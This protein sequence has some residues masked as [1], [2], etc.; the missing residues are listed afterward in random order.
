MNLTV[1]I[2]NWSTFAAVIVE[3]KV[4]YCQRYR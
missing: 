4:A 1:K 2:R 3:I